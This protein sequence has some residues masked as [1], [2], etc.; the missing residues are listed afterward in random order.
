MG[1]NRMSTVK[2]MDMAGWKRKSMAGCFKG[3]EEKLWLP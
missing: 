1:I 3:P 2:K